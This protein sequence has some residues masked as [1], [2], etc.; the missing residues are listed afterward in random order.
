MLINK[1]ALSMFIVLEKISSEFCVI[2]VDDQSFAMFLIVF[3]VT[4]ENMILIVYELAKAVFLIPFKIAFE[5]KTFFFVKHN[6]KSLFLML[7][8]KTIVDVAVLVKEPSFSFPQLVVHLPL[9]RVS[10][11][12]IYV[13][14]L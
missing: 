6:S 10:I 2:L 5:Y 11:R 3:P 9:I 7:L 12:V 13:Y 1:K 4:S 8:P 14:P